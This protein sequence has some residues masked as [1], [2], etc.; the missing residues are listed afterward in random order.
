MSYI[1]PKDNKVKQSQEA[2]LENIR[3]T[4]DF[5]MIRKVKTGTKTAK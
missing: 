4:K 3:E 5:D 1:G 2:F